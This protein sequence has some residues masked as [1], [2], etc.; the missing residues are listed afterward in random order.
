MSLPWDDSPTEE[1]RIASVFNGGVSLAVW[2]GGATHELN[3]LVRSSETD[4]PYSA[5]L[6]L[7]CSKAVADVVAGTSAGGINGAALAVA[8]AN[9]NADL[10]VLRDV[11]S[12]QGRFE[13]LLRK[14]FQGNPTSLLRGDE[15]F[16]PALSEAMTSLA[17]ATGNTKPSAP[18]IDVQITTS[19]LE[20]SDRVVPDDLGQLTH[21][22]I[23]AA[24]FH[25]D[26]EDFTKT[27]LPTTARQLRLPPERA[28]PS[29][30]PLT[31]LL[32]VNHP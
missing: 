2:M 20:P 21:Q 8:Q 29:R 31:D 11:W 4:G 5:L 6:K 18:D 22:Q 10:S 7:V 28:P 27:A 13:S 30:S 32:P 26:A 15:F 17:S 3:R 25:F 19:L 24:Q 16:L 23:H 1:L 12:E 9:R 14:P